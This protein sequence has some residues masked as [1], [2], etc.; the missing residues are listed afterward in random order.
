MLFGM[1]E[2]IKYLFTIYFTT[3]KNICQIQLLHFNDKV[4][5]L[6]LGVFFR[7]IISFG[8]NAL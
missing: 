4:E 1:R 6:R 8:D 7:K 5:T 3:A 2:L